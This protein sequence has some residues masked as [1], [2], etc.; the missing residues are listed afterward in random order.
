MFGFTSKCEREYG[1]WTRVSRREV[2]I[3]SSRGGGRRGGEE[4]RRV[5][6]DNN[7]SWGLGSLRAR[8]GSVSSE[9]RCKKRVLEGLDRRHGRPR[10][11][12]QSPAG[13]A[14]ILRRARRP[15]CSHPP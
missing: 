9:G 15:N 13:K 11:P 8:T 4:E 7:V 5:E 10:G 2:A 3:E 6:S 12:A 1:A 14:L